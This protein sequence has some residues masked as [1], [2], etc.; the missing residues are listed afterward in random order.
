MREE[1]SVIYSDDNLKN[2]Y[3]ASI[4]SLGDI[5]KGMNQ[6]RD[7]FIL[8]KNKCFGSESPHLKKEQKLRELLNDP[9]PELIEKPDYSYNSE[10][11]DVSRLINKSI[12]EKIKVDEYRNEKQHLNEEKSRQPHIE[13]L[14]VDMAHDFPDNNIQINV[15]RLKLDD[16]MNNKKYSHVK[17]GKINPVQSSYSIKPIID[18]NFKKHQELLKDFVL[19]WLVSFSLLLISHISSKDF[20]SFVIVKESLL[21]LFIV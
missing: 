5:Y 19:E 12:Y 17:S 16:N 14:F 21:F 7:S 20:R 18:H 1:L 6:S 4:A 10:D 3:D 11:Q 13:N 15:K 8:K 9:D 2:K